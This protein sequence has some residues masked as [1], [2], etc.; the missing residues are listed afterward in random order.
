MGRV[1]VDRWGVPVQAGNDRG[2]VLP[3]EAIGGLA[4]LVGDPV[5]G[6]EAAVAA[7]DDLLL[8]H[9]YRAHLSLCGTSAEGAAAEILKK[10]EGPA[11]VKSSTCGPPARSRSKSR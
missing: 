11:S 1:F 6:A 3:D 7:D 9:L 4:A 2:V 8:G 5:A 10:L